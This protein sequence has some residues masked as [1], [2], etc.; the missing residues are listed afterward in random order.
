MFTAL[1]VGL[2]VAAIVNWWLLIQISASIHHASHTSGRGIGEIYRMTLSLQEHA[3]SLETDLLGR[4]WHT[5]WPGRLAKAEVEVV[6]RSA[7]SP[8]GVPRFPNPDP[9]EN[10][11]EYTTHLLIQKYVTCDAVHRVRL[12][13]QLRAVASS[14][15]WPAW[16]PHELATL[17]VADENEFVRLWFASHARELETRQVENDGPSSSETTDSSILKILKADP[18]QF[19]RAALLSNPE[20]RDLPWSRSGIRLEDDWKA[21]LGSYT[22]LECIALMYNP[23]LELNFLLELMRNTSQT[24]GIGPELQDLM[25]SIGIRN[26]EIIEWSR[27]CG[28]TSWGEFF[29]PDQRCAEIWDLAFG[30]WWRF[31]R[32]FEFRS[33]IPRFTALYIQTTPDKKLEVYRRFEEGKPDANCQ[34]RCYVLE[35]CMMPGDEPILRIGM[36]DEDELCRRQSEWKIKSWEKRHFDRDSDIH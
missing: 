21:R 33:S 22:R 7:F 2:L 35:G 1:L 27:R 20:S 5:V 29:C 4:E 19:V 9:F 10:H 18:S 6:H 31:H 17:V 14:R 28:R 12:L 26:P 34:F 16:I 25:V 23:T 3:F 15:L 11:D 8:L 13:E 36:S 32:T 30:K 24:L